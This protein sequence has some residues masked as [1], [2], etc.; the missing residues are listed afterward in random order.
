[1]FAMPIATVIQEM[2]AVRFLS[3]L[4][5]PMYAYIAVEYPETLKEFLFMVFS[6]NSDLLTKRRP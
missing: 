1:M 6:Q 3:V 5:S 2:M 4:N